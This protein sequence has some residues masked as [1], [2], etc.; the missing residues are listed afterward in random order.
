MSSVLQLHPGNLL[1]AINPR[2]L[3]KGGGDRS[4]DILAQ[5]TSKRLR[6]GVVVAVARPRVQAY[7]HDG[8]HAKHE[9]T[10]G[11]PNEVVDASSQFLDPY[12]VFLSGLLYGVAA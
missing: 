7:E 9:Q 5:S 1:L 2:L 12:H 11:C 4:G 10:R 3:E 6:Q 8:E